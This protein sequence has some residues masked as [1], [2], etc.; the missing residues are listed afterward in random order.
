MKT[1]VIVLTFIFML[2]FLSIS[3]NKDGNPFTPAADVEEQ[4]SEVVNTESVASTGSY[5]NGSRSAK[6]EEKGSYQRPKSDFKEKSRTSNAASD[7]STG[8]EVSN[9]TFN[10]ATASYNPKLKTKPGGNKGAFRDNENDNET[11]QDFRVR[12]Q[13]S[14][15]NINWANSM[16]LVTVRISGEGFEE[17]NPDTLWLVG[18]EGAVTGPP[19]KAKVGP[20]SVVAKFLKSEAIGIIL[21]PQRGVSYDIQVMGQFNDETDL[22]LPIAEIIVVGK[23]YLAGDLS[24]VIRPKKW[25]IAWGN[26]DDNG[27]DSENVVTARISGERFQEIDPASVQMAYPDGGMP[28]ISPIPGSYEF[29]GVSFVIKFNQSDAIGLI[30]DPKRGDPPHLIHV[31]G[32]FTDLTPFDVTYSITISG[33]KSGEGRLTLEIKP[34]TWNMAW[35][36]DGDGEVTARI[37]GEDFDKIDTL[38]PIQMRG[39]AGTPINP[40]GTE[41]AGF[42]FIAKFSQSQAIALIPDSPENKYDI[43][44]SFYLTDEIIER[45]LSD[46]VFIKGKKK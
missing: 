6:S 13:P 26:D 33:K 16:G 4:S 41:L 23:K 14:K 35:A 31:S 36:A 37:K 22:D 25:N 46:E 43:F 44:V 24:L 2:S 11:T 39:P 12:I 5:S 3:C 40:I 27:D 28:P 1:K 8:N 10:S 7:A 42:S 15:W 21:E 34:N 17:I 29:G 45:E 20:Y 9:A 30:P 19:S 32:E 18:P 38:Q